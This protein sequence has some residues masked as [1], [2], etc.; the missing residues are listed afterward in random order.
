[1]RLG[2]E[3]WFGVILFIG[4]PILSFVLYQLGIIQNLVS[5]IEQFVAIILG[6]MIVGGVSLVYHGRPKRNFG[7]TQLQDQR[8]NLLLHEQYRS[9]HRQGIINET[10]DTWGKKLS[11]PRKILDI[12]RED[13]ENIKINFS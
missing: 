2:R 6:T 4:A 13:D 3:Q 5:V 12:M 7:E 1:M 10:R 11:E 8:N 9:S